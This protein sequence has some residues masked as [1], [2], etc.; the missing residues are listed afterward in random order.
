MNIQYFG[1]EEWEKD[2]VKGKLP[3]LEATFFS[4]SLQEEPAAGGEDVEVLSVFVKSK[5][6]KEEMDRFPNLKLVVTRSTGFD[7]IDLNEAAARNIVVSN[8]PTYGANT[9]AEFAFALLLT[10]S[11]KTYDAYDRISETGSFSQ[12]GLRGFDLEG[13][14]IGIVGCGNIGVHAVKIAKGFGMNVLVSD[15]HQDEDLARELGFTYASLDDLLAQSDIIS[16]HVPY[17]EHTHHLIN[18]GN[19][20]KVKKGAYLINTSRGQVVETAALVNGLEQGIFAG[21]GLDVL[22]EEKDMGHEEEVFFDSSVSQERMKTVLANHYLIDHPRV[23]ITPHN[24]F[25]TK[26]A[27]ERIV[28]TTVENITAFINGTPQNIVKI[29]EN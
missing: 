27:I 29:K 3:E 24:G 18:S 1:A 6:G 14:T 13:K 10:I 19:L 26:E 20:S 21:A 11:R 15:V 16:L 8:V 5:V 23:I 22:E 28:D 7:H 9:V 25:N 2:Y 17:N 12:D 4:G